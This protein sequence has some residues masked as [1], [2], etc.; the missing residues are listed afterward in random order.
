MQSCAARVVRSFRRACSWQSGG[1]T[2]STGS[3][4]KM[5]STKLVKLPALILDPKARRRFR[6]G[7]DASRQLETPPPA[8]V[9]LLVPFRRASL[10]N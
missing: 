5:I 6:R 10:Q 2:A 8:L 1:S 3:N 4:S 7:R 9:V